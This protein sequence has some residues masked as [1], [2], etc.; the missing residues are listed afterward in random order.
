MPDRPHHSEQMT[1]CVEEVK[2]KGHDESS[3]YAICTTQMQQSKQPIFASAES[4]SAKEYF[5][6]NY[7]HMRTCTITHAEDKWH[8]YSN[9]G[10]KLGAYEQEEDALAHEQRIEEA[11][12][13]TPV[14]L[15]LCG[16]LNFA[17]IRHESKNGIDYLVVPVVSLME[18]VIHPVNASTPEY[19]PLASLQKSAASWNGR[20]IVIGHPVKNGRQ[21]SADDPAILEERGIG[22]IDNSRVE[23]VKMLQEAWIDKKKVM[24][25]HSD[26]YARLLAGK[27]VEVSVGAFVSAAKTTGQFNGKDYK[28][29]WGDTTGD[30]LAFLPDGRGACSLEMGCGACR[31]AEA[32]DITD[33]EFRAA[34][35]KMSDADFGQELRALL[36]RRNNTDDEKTIQS[37]HDMSML[38]GAKCDR[39]NYK[40]MADGTQPPCGCKTEQHG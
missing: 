23:G 29:I 18:G 12:T 21:C 37:L 11:K 35:F 38:L 16:A 33:G 2:A 39:S 4:R 40:M 13:L 19:V 20:P 28:A 27:P 22:F 15:H 7:L 25:L 24:T 32:Y 5:L 9:D 36:G 6:T 30:H 14:Q 31:A 1:R 8:L 10:V 3:A 34:S 26:M 17:S